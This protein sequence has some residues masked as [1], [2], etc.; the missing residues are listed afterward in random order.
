MRKAQTMT[1]TGTATLALALAAVGS[2]F[3]ATTAGAQSS[4]YVDG[5]TPVDPR[6]QALVDAYFDEIEN[7]RQA[8]AEERERFERFIHHDNIFGPQQNGRF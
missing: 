3:A 4:I 7:R 5:R 6:T 1:R 8:R 2:V